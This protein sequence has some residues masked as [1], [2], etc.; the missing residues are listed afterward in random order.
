[1]RVIIY[2]HSQVETNV[3]CGQG[4]GNNTTQAAYVLHVRVIK[5]DDDNAS[6]TLDNATSFLCRR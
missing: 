3:K 2:V 6:N 5:Q 1:M 4:T